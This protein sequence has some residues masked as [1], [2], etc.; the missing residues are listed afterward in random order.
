MENFEDSLIGNYNLCSV[1]GEPIASNTKIICSEAC[2]SKFTLK[3][4][5]SN[6]E[7]IREYLE[8]YKEFFDERASNEIITVFDSEE[9]RFIELLKFK[10]NQKNVDLS[11]IKYMVDLIGSRIG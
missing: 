9:K 10:L 7:L 5:V 8:E 1:C 4:F 11:E 6:I 3:I 2:E